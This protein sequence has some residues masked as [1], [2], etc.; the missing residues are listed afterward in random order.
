M[1]TQKIKLKLQPI[2]A[3]LICIANSNLSSITNRFPNTHTPLFAYG[4][5]KE[6]MGLLTAH[7]IF[8]NRRYNP[9]MLIRSCLI[10]PPK[11]SID[12][13]VDEIL[14]LMSSL[15]LYTLPVF[16]D[17][18]NVS[19]IIKVKAI[20]KDLFKNDI[21]AETVIDNVTKRP[22]ITISE[23]SNI[24]D[25]FQRFSKHAISRLVV[26]G[27]NKKL[28][29]VVTK[30]D[31]LSL[32]LSQ[33]KRQ[34]FSTR[35]HPKNYSFDTEQ[36]KRDHQPLMKYVSPILDV[37]DETTDTYLAIRKLLESTYNSV[38]LVDKERVPRFTITTKD[39][40][41]TAVKITTKVPYLLT[42]VSNLPSE[43]SQA[44]KNKVNQDL[45][46][47]S[48]WINKQQNHQLMRFSSKVIY[49]PERKP[50]LFIVKLKITTDS[51][52]Y[53]AQNKDRDFLQ[54]TKEVIKQVE[55]QVRRRY[56][57]L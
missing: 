44:E 5:N 56:K 8:R 50:V 46:K 9:L 28:K 36:I 4:D 23:N 48:L 29:G 37:L 39:V 22:V 55:K 31:I 32:Y 21:F 11:L 18:G 43:L 14:R 2:P 12:T 13:S 45:R 1:R 6:F 16:D 34:R 24:G 7:N 30:R 27:K 51:G 40:L 17:I 25:A 49:S 10:S 15:K 52:S 57:T 38:I 20:L 41:K 54:A 47:I 42:I 35:S 26:V 33:T 53:F 3:R 19:G